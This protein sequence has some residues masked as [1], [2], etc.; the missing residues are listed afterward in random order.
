MKRILRLLFAALA[1]LFI[2]P[3][4][5]P[6][7]DVPH[8]V[9]K[10]PQGCNSC[11]VMHVAEPTTCGGA[12]AG[13]TH[14]DG[15]GGC[16]ANDAACPGTCNVAGG[17]TCT[18]TDG[19]R[20]CQCPPNRTGADCTACAAGYSGGSCTPAATTCSSV[21]QSCAAGLGT[22]QQTGCGG[23]C[24]VGQ[25]N[26][27]TTGACVADETCSGSPCGAG[28]CSI[29]S[30]VRVCSCSLAY[31]QGTCGS[32]AAGYA[33]YPA[34]TLVTCTVNGAACAGGHGTCAL[35]SADCNVDSCSGHHAQAS[36]ICEADQGNTC[37]A[38]ALYT[39]N[40]GVASCQCK[41]NFK[42][43]G[44]GGFC[45]VCAT[46]YSGAGCTTL[47]TGT[48]NVT[49]DLCAD[50][51]GR[52]TVTSGT[53]TSQVAEADT[54]WAVGGWTNSAE[55]GS[56]GGNAKRSFSAGT[57]LSATFSINA[58]ASS[59]SYRVWVAWAAIKTSNGGASAMSIVVKI[60]GVTVGTISSTATT[61]TW[62]AAP[63]GNYTM[64]G[65]SHTITFTCTPGTLRACG[66]DGFIVTTDTALTPTYASG[67]FA[68]AANWD[69]AS[70][71]YYT[72]GGGAKSC[73]CATS[74][75]YTADCLGCK[76]GYHLEGGVCIAD[77]TGVCA[78]QTCS[79]HGTCFVKTSSKGT[80]ATG[81]CNCTGEYYDNPADG[82]NP[83]SCDTCSKTGGFQCNANTGYTGANVD[84]CAAGYHKEGNACVP[85]PN[86][87]SG[88]TC[89]GR[90]ACF[91]NSTG[92]GVCD[93]TEHYYSASDP[94]SCSSCAAPSFACQCKPGYTGTNCLQCA[95]GYHL[96]GG[97]CVLDTAGVCNSS[98]PCNPVQGTCYTRSSSPIVPAVAA[99]V[100]KEHFSGANCNQCASAPPSEYLLNNPAGVN[101]LCLGCHSAAGPGPEVDTHMSSIAGGGDF[102]FTML[103]ST[104]HDPHTQPT[105][106]QIPWTNVRGTRSFLRKTVN[107]PNSG[108]KTV[109]LAASSGPNSFADGTSPYDGYCEVC[110]TLTTHHR[111]STSGGDHTHEAGND[112]RACH[113]HNDSSANAFGFSP[114]G[115]DCVGCHGAPQPSNV[116]TARRPVTLDFATANKSH[117][118][119]R[120]F[121]TA[122]LSKFDCVL[123]HLEGNS[124]GSTSTFHKN[125]TVN[126]RDLDDASN[127]AWSFTD[128]DTISNTPNTNAQVTNITKFCQRCHDGNG[129]ADT[130]FI[131]SVDTNDTALTRTRYN[132][133][134]DGADLSIVMPVGNPPQLNV[135]AISPQFDIY[136]TFATSGGPAPTHSISWFWKSSGVCV[137]DCP[138]GQ[139]NNSTGVC[140][141]N[142]TCPGGCVNGQKCSIE[143]GIAT[144]TCGPAYAGATC[145]TCAPGYTGYPNCVVND[146]TTTGNCANGRGTCAR[147]SGTWTCTC[148]AAY[149]PTGAQGTAACSQ[150]AMGYVVQ[151]GACVAKAAS[152]CGGN[153]CS[154]NGAC[155]V[156]SPLP[157]G[158]TA[159][160]DC[161]GQAYGA[162]CASCSATVGAGWMRGQKAPTSPG[163]NT[164]TWNNSW[165]ENSTTE[166][167]DCHMPGNN[168]ATQKYSMNAHGSVNT[169]WML[170]SM[171]GLDEA[172]TVSNAPCYRCHKSTSYYNANAGSRYPDHSQGAHMVPADSYYGSL[173]G[174]PCFNC[175][176]GKGYGAIHGENDRRDAGIGTPFDAYIFLNGSAIAT[177]QTFPG[178]TFTCGAQAST[179]A[180]DLGCTQHS[181]GGQ[182]Y[183]R[184]Y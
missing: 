12:C 105:A 96:E 106:V 56:N 62:G 123:C 63:L 82:A 79:A 167:A 68:T 115:G 102:N 73:S 38:N 110:H 28:T 54:S 150:C 109:T 162:T 67:A 182:G 70:N 154:G 3:S 14:A 129:I 34:C 61:W 95:A 126:L 136:K 175:H 152:L 60:D 112:C 66:I 166:C 141:A 161:F 183:T 72:A 13:G 31:T 100:C 137:G 83:L 139:Y 134:A 71:D 87:C 171:T 90:G 11:H 29:V 127:T 51:A 107:T 143:H 98:S 160:C 20:Q 22:C 27:Q 144:C 30:G 53:E 149:A 132:P 48:C 168:T 169:N 148:N 174:A 21:G 117:H 42:N 16:V 104:C 118:I 37:G 50:G 94:L 32:C 80:P 179:D 10:L 140:T 35:L 76:A 64:A 91:L 1:F 69:L 101:S 153:T 120:N 45:N 7:L 43:D 84:Q 57:V 172:L 25:H 181:G 74:A 17:A 65:G 78:G 9:T 44:L 125:A 157:T 146:C 49:G 155:Y 93:C 18:Y 176:G 131:G 81:L 147:I 164:T 58:A 114:S 41:P 39:D 113:K 46:G 151:N 24:P 6:A 85:D 158:A 156:N 122:P 124:D 121:T 5:L 19:V 89:S 15:L 111:N 128:N 75:A 142:A 55:A 86:D 163:I 184:V 130:A 116:S 8:D 88:Q 26:S 178:P 180:W 99:C 77:G 145:N 119:Q 135:P 92:G 103:C 133:F 173:T 40:D 138:Y 165:T 177:W 23:E 52:C 47:D 97:T 170:G 4:T 36:N 108:A 159:V 2:A 33:G 59:L